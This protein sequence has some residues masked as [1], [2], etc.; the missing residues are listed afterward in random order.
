MEGQSLFEKEVNE[1]ND[2]APNPEEAIEDKF[3]QE[4][5]ETAREILEKLTQ[6]DFYRKEEIDERDKKRVEEI[7]K[8]SKKEKKI[9]EFLSL[10]KHK[11][12]GDFVIII[13]KKAKRLFFSLRI[14]N[15]EAAV[16]RHKKRQK[17]LM[18]KFNGR[19]IESKVMMVNHR[20]SDEELMKDWQEILKHFQES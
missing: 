4:T 16:E 13:M 12:Y 10:E 6:V 14:K 1:F 5:R 18:M 2:K 7:L 11:L 17:E 20:K 9:V 15:S 8:K 19:F 3:G